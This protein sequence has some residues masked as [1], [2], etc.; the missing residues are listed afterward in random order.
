METESP[1]DRRYSTSADSMKRKKFEKCT[2]PAMS[3]STNSMRRVVR[4]RCA[5]CR[6]LSKAHGLRPVG[7]GV[8]THLDPRDAGRGLAGR[9]SQ[10]VAL[11]NRQRL[12]CHLRRREVFV[13]GLLA[14]AAHF[15]AH[16]MIGE[17]LLK[18]ACQI[19]R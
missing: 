15:F 17:H 16:C 18:A 9:S 19:R 2:M 1:S 8:C 5:I 14:L 6:L 13:H 4:K 7:R 11:I 3:V 10:Q 12:T